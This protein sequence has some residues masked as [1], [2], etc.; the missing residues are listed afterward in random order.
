[1]AV[2]SILKRDIPEEIIPND[3]SAKTLNSGT[4]GSWSAWGQIAASTSMP[5]VL[6]GVYTMEIF[7]LTTQGT[8]SGVLSLQIGTGGAGAEQV[9]GEGHGGLLLAPGGTSQAVTGLKGQTMFFEPILIPSGTRLSVRATNTTTVAVLLGIYLFGYDA[10]KF[11]LPLSYVREERYVKGLC[12]PAQGAV[13]YPSGSLT[14]V[15]SGAGVFVYGSWTQFIASASRP[16]LITGLV[17]ATTT[18][19]RSFQAKIGIG[20]A[21]SEVAMSKLGLPGRLGIPGPLCDAYLPRPLFVKAGERVA[22]QI[23]AAA[24]SQTLNTGLKGFEVL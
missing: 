5:F 16:T 2:D 4:S 17:G 7:Q 11:G 12:A 15:T 10:S 8:Q 9:V 18:L 22:V 23:A 13:C 21:G 1:M 3:A 19:H 6:C 14:P 20:A 24:S